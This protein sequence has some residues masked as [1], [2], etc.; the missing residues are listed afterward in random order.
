MNQN[1][2]NPIEMVN[3]DGTGINPNWERDSRDRHEAH[4]NAMRAGRAAEAL[5]P[6]W[7]RTRDMVTN[8][9]GISY[10]QL[11]NTKRWPNTE[12]RTRNH[13]ILD[14][15]RNAGE[16]FWTVTRLTDKEYLLAAKQEMGI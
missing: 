7:T 11:D 9:I 14:W 3:A 16:G 13:A 12:A 6:D 8:N 10:K 4:G 5:I 1:R 15:L 2:R